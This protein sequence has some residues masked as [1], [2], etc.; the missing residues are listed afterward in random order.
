MGKFQGPT[1]KRHVGWSNDEQFMQQ[2]LTRG[3]YL[4]V[5]ERQ[6]LGE[7][8]LVR[9]GLKNGKATF[10]GNKRLLQASQKSGGTIVGLGT[11]L[12]VPAT[13]VRKLINLQ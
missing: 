7:S 11:S 1:P 12:H 3:G 2:I 5:H 4:S 6:A 10:S 13:L 8:K 9:K